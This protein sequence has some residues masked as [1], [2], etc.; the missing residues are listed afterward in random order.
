MYIW[1][2]GECKL[3]P[4]K[5]FRE[6]LSHLP[7]LYI[8]SAMSG[9]IWLVV[10]FPL[11]PEHIKTRSFIL[12]LEAKHQP[13]SSDTLSSTLSGE[14]QLFY[15]RLFVEALQTYYRSSLPLTRGF[16]NVNFQCHLQKGNTKINGHFCSPPRQEDLQKK[17]PVVT[18]PS[19]VSVADQTEETFNQKLQI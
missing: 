12:T 17:T 13:Q 11:M 8:S 14:A 16:Q 2:E 6:S 5:C 7:N 19:A 18:T 9:H 3:V 15:P 4:K 10:W 1:L